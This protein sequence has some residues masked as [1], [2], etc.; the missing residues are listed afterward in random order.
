MP[1]SFRERFMNST[2]PA[3]LARCLEK[4]RIP[5]RLYPQKQ[6]PGVPERSRHL[7]RSNLKQEVWKQ[8]SKTKSGKTW[9]GT[10]DRRI[11]HQLINSLS[12]YFQGFV[13]P[14][15]LFGISCIN[16]IKHINSVFEEGENSLGTMLNCCDRRKHQMST[17]RTGTMVIETQPEKMFYLED[18]PS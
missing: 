11:L 3:L 4:A 1:L 7:T 2:E 14:R 8:V 12:H 18:H 17:L 16:S 15:W 13:H 9:C 10:V 6:R 5:T